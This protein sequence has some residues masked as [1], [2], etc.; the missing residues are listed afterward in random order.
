MYRSVP[1]PPRSDVAI[2][3]ARILPIADADG[4]RAEPI[5]NGTIV[6]ADGVI[7]ALGGPDTAIPAGAE[8]I[9]AV[10][11]Q[12]HLEHVVALGSG[13]GDGPEDPHARGR[14]AESREGPDR[15]ASGPARPADQR[16]HRRPQAQ[17]GCS[18]NPSPAPL[19]GATAGAAGVAAVVAA[20]AAVPLIGK[21]S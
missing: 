14:A 16:Q 21:A 8:T 11:L 12:Q 5:D 7:A 2:V 18:H 3:G 19:T 6:L 9:D 15:Q 1:V 10:V 20:G 13:A 17:V 4:T